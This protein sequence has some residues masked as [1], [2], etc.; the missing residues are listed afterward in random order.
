MSSRKT[1]LITGSSI[2]IGRATAEHFQKSGWNVVATM[3]NPDAGKDLAALDNVL[4]TK[5]DVTDERSIEAAAAAAVERFGGIDVLVNN[6]GYG[7]YGVLEATSVD[8]IRRQYDTNVI[9]LLAMTKAVMPGFRKQHSGVIVNVGSIG[10]RLTF[11]FGTLY[12]ST[13]FAVEGISEALSF[14][15]REIGVRV[16]LVEPGMIRTNFANAIEF[17]NDRS[18]AEYQ[19]LIGKMFEAVG[20]LAAAG[21]EPSVVAEVIYAAATDGTDQ[22]RYTAGED[23]KR[24]VADRDS[25]DDATFFA[26]LRSL[27]GQ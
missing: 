14:E 26:Q 18:L 15:T 2:G 5:L 22:L 9:G 6:A 24:L 17:S 20:T 13:K 25:K 21:S 23:A 10:G 11:P 27:F 3:R 16:K 8:S 1:V 7:A 19:P 12:M 4:V